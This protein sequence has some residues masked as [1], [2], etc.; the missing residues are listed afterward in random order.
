M[1]FQRN[2]ATSWNY[3][4][5]GEMRDVD[6]TEHQKVAFEETGSLILMFI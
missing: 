6:V 1:L 4:S 2:R 5:G 3:T